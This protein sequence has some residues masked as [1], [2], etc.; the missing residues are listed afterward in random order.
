[1]MPNTP[2]SSTCLAIH[3]FISPPFGGMRTNGVTF[4]ASVPPWTS[5]RRSSMYW[6]AS[7]S[8][9]GL[10]GACSIS[11]ATPSKG[12]PASAVAVS[13]SGEAKPQ[14]AT[15][16][17]SRALMTPLRRGISGMVVSP[18]VR[19]PRSGDLVLEPAVDPARVALEDLAPILGAELER[20]DVALGVVVVAAGL[21]VDAADRADHLRGEQDVVDGDHPVPACDPGLVVDGG[22]EE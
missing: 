11:N 4:G 18:T 17:C 9:G 2:M 10:I 1:M 7:R 6:S 12:E 19:L 8:T 20:L 16:P 21:G 5:W 14:K 15:F 13:M 3:W 22:V